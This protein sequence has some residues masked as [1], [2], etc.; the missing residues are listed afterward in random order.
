MNKKA[1]ESNIWKFYLYRIFN[2]LVFVSPIFYLFYQQNGLSMTEIMILQS[3]YTAVILFSVVPSGIIADYI[4]RK[5]LLIAN[6]FFY[7]LAW[8]FYALSSS[9]WSFFFCEIVIALSTAVW[10]ASGTAFF[11]DTL[12]EIGKEQ[13]FNKL[14]GKVVSINYLFWGLSA[15]TAG[16]IASKDIRLT[17]WLTAIASLISLIISFSFTETKRYKHGDRKYFTHLK[18]AISFAAKH[19]KVR[20]YLISSA[21]FFAVNFVGYVMFQPYLEKLSVPL[22]YFG[23]IYFA[24]FLVAAVGSKFAGKAEKL[25][26]EKWILLSLMLLLLL[27]I[28]GMSFEIALIGMLFPIIIN[29]SAGMFEP[30]ITDYIN[31]NV[32]SHHRATIA[33][34]QSLLIEVL[35]TL[36]AP[37]IGWAADIY[38]LKAAF[39]LLAVILGINLT[40]LAGF[41]YLGERD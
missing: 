41:Y 35:C 21:L 40:V 12:K 37:F 4:G 7:F 9:F 39:I 1:L 14:Y 2:C 17:F 13:S 38:S 33:S 19:V 23:V 26:G 20:I 31:K 28:I 25:F 5:K 3:V 11:Y 15:L 34:L 16:Y 6:S 24:M 30:I 29:F 18:D 32:G 8:T 27:P 10:N 36:I 22:I